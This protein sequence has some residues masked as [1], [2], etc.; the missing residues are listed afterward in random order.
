MTIYLSHAEMLAGGLWKKGVVLFHEIHGV[1]LVV[2]K[3]EPVDPN[4]VG[5]VRVL[6]PEEVQ[7][8][9]EY[10]I[11]TVECRRY[12]LPETK[13]TSTPAIRRVEGPQM[14]AVVDPHLD[15][16]YIWG[17]MCTGRR[18]LDVGCGW[19]YG[20]QIMARY[21]KEVVAIDIDASEVG[22]A[23]A[24]HTAPNLTYVCGRLEDYKGAL[25][26]VEICTE[27]LEHLEDD[28]MQS[29]LRAMRRLLAPG[30]MLLFTTPCQDY[31]KRGDNVHHIREFCYVDLLQVLKV[32]FKPVGA[33]WYD[34]KTCTVSNR[35]RSDGRDGKQSYVS[36]CIFC[37]SKG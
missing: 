33:W 11:E 15:R 2:E 37:R 21:A 26:N 31:T 12:V 24:N 28:A 13:T 22:F 14:G 17:P 27:V 10:A 16:F 8:G 29:L 32:F 20:A 5:F 3:N 23:R 7:R 35:Y 34:W 25:F 18:V 6:S 1:Y 36:Q 4:D 30:G 19:G 9:V